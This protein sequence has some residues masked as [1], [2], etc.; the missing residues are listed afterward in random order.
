MCDSIVVWLVAAVFFLAG[1][2]FALTWAETERD[3]EEDD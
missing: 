3:E 1:A 2:C